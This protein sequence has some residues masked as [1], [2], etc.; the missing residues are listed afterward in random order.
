MILLSFLKIVMVIFTTDINLNLSYFLTP[1]FLIIWLFI[2]TD[3]N[4]RKGVYHLLK[5]KN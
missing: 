1:L 5:N 2:T 3:K 4:E